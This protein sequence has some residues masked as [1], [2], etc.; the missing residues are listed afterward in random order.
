MNQVQINQNVVGRWGVGGGFQMVFVLW[1]IAGSLQLFCIR[2]LHES[3]L[4]PFL[5]Y[6]TE[7]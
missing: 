6:G 5:M 1:L 2:I 4:V 3:L 7:K